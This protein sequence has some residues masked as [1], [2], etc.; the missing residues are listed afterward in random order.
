M[1]GS[2]CS[3]RVKPSKKL[4]SAAK[5]SKPINNVVYT[6]CYCSF[7]NANP[8]TPKA[9]VRGKLAEVAACRSTLTGKSC[10]VDV[11]TPSPS[12]QAKHVEGLLI[13]PGTGKKSRRKGWLTLKDLAASSIDSTSLA[14]KKSA[15]FENL[16]KSPGAFQQSPLNKRRA[17]SMASP[18][19]LSLPFIIEGEPVVL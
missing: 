11:F 12:P 8:G 15:S 9:Y 4:S 18:S 19:P 7:E 14:N 3:V 16:T 17:K 5:T 2:N 1:V 10:T 13:T 6:C